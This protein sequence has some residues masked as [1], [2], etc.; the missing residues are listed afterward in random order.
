MTAAEGVPHVVDPGALDARRRSEHLV[1]IGVVQMEAVAGDVAGNLATAERLVVELA[2]RGVDLV[3]LPELFATGYDL[4]VDL[5]DVS[6]PIDGAHVE[7]LRT[8]AQ[9][10]DLVVA[11]ALLVREGADLVDLALVVDATGVVA[12]SSKQY[13]WGAE[14]D[15][16]A[17]RPGPSALAKTQIGTIGVAICYEAGFPEVVRD[18]AVRGADIVAVPAAFGRARLYAW[19]LLTRSRALENGC[20]VAAAG[21]TGANATGVEFAAH[22]R[23]VSPTGEVLAGLGLATGAA[24]ATVDLTEIARSREAIPYLRDL[25]RRADAETRVRPTETTGETHHG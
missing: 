11:T 24:S 22:S 6:E 25:A 16:F 13:L 2:A 10:H 23:I 19:E 1:R 18:L 8:W 9:R 15:S 4:G 3:V 14:P 5:G 20:Y 12:C 21:L 7:L 17:V